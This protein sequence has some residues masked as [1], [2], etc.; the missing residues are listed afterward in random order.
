M[1]GL[2]C[3]EGLYYGTVPA[4]SCEG[5]GALGANAGVIRCSRHSSA[6]GEAGSS[7]GAKQMLPPLNPA[8]PIFDGQLAAIMAELEGG[9][10]EDYHF[11]VHG[12]VRGGGGG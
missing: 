4:Q 6:S 7:V 8:V 11:Q 12:G 5:V 10:P 1:Q 2:R 3:R 9:D